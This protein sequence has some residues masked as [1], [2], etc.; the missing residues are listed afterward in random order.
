MFLVSL[1]MTIVATAI[2]KITDD[3]TALQNPGLL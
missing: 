1:D 2:P 3:Y